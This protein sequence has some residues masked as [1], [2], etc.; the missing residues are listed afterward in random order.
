MKWQYKCDALMCVKK[1]DMYDNSTNLS[2]NYHNLGNI[3]F[4]MSKID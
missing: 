2:A 3:Q 4:G 1:E